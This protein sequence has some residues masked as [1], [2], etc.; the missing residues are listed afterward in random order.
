[1]VS[2]ASV[3]VWRLQDPQAD[4]RETDNSE[5]GKAIRTVVLVKNWDPLALSLEVWVGP[6]NLF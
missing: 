1:M 4:A 2:S 5:Q 6:R 3:R